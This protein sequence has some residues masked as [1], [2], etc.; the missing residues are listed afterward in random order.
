V[1][2]ESVDAFHARKDKLLAT[3]DAPRPAQPRKTILLASEKA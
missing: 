3:F 2:H 1:K